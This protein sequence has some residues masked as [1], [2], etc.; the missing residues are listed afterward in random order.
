MNNY[1]FILRIAAGMSRGNFLY[2]GTLRD[3]ASWRL[4][5]G[6]ARIRSGAEG[7]LLIDY[8]AVQQRN[9]IDLPETQ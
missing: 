2:E 3:A 9:A 4:G 1:V 6:L 8:S 5:R 7:E